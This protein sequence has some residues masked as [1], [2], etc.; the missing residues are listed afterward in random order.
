M[1]ASDMAA[2][3]AG[4]GVTVLIR[5]RLRGDP[6]QSKALHDQVTAA[7]REAAQAAGDLTHRVFLD[8]RDP[9]AFL[10]ID[11]WRSPEAVAAFSS[12]PR[13]AEFFAQLF[14]GPPEVTVWIPSGWNEW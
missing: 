2:M 13:I 14:D 12:D 5:A 4:P 10:G 8:P 6:E 11:E 9:G 1:E 3:D 7:T